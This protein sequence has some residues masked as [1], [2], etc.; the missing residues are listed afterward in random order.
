MILGKRKIEFS[1]SLREESQNDLDTA[2][3]EEAG[4]VI[5]RIGD[6]QRSISMFLNTAL[7]KDVSHSALI[8][9]PI[10]RTNVLK[11]DTNFK[12]AVELFDFI[13]AYKDDGYVVQRIGEKLEGFPELMEADFAEILAES[14]YLTYRYGGKL[15]QLME[16][17]YQNQNKKV[18]ESEDK[19][20]KE[21]LNALKKR[22]TSGDKGSAL[23]YSPL[24]I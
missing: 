24:K 19:A 11:M 4:S 23:S 17:R 21:A 5:A 22:L 6:I 2:Y 8:K 20:A 18:R 10:T 3:D 7:M 15:D 14:S 9:P 13:S 1:L 12:T 16:Q